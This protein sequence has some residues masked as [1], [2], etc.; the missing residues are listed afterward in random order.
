MKFKPYYLI[1]NSGILTALIG[2][3]VTYLFVLLQFKVT[4]MAERRKLDYAQAV[5]TLSNVTA[6]IQNGL[7]AK[8]TQNTSTNKN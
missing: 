3:L 5:R 1:L 8:H 4:D 2:S 7:I 6:Q